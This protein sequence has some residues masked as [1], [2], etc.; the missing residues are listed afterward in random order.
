[1]SF[2]A[3]HIAAGYILKMMIKM[4]IATGT[5]YTLTEVIQ[6]QEMSRDIYPLR[7]ASHDY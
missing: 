6:I 1:M 2:I 5:G 7:D 4:R 3:H